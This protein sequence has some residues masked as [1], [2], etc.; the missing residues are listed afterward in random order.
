[1]W[2]PLIKNTRPG[3]S[4]LLDKPGLVS[5][6]GQRHCVRLMKIS[7]LGSH[8][9][10]GIKCYP[11]QGQVTRTAK[12]TCQVVTKAYIITKAVSQHTFTHH[13]VE[14]I[15]SLSE[16]SQLCKTKGNLSLPILFQEIPN[17]SQKSDILF[18]I[19]MF[20]NFSVSILCGGFHLWRSIWQQ[21]QSKVSPAA[22][23]AWRSLHWP[24]PSEHGCSRAL[25]KCKSAVKTSEP[26][27][28]PTSI[29]LSSRSLR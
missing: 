18:S 10:Q 29:R 26:P 15:L 7:W 2:H 24:F 20:W 25:L 28:P 22:G 9:C 14:K 19:T 17:R 27:Y 21:H 12:L 5:A 4:Q 3:F 13:R 1:M 16:V 11:S 6:L 8:R 23:W